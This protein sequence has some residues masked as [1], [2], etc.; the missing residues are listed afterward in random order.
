MLYAQLS[1]EKNVAKLESDIVRSS[2]ARSSNVRG[3]NVGDSNE[4]RL[5]WPLVASTIFAHDVHPVSQDFPYYWMLVDPETLNTLLISYTHDPA[6]QCTLMRMPNRQD[7]F[8]GHEA[9]CVSM[10]NASPF[11]SPEC[12]ALRKYFRQESLSGV[13]ADVVK[14]VHLLTMG[15]HKDTHEA[16][17]QHAQLIFA[18]APLLTLNLPELEAGVW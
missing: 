15:L 6:A 4:S 8:Y 7:W 10:E 11:L 5:I 9:G 14:R 2:K 18:P 1:T 3:S 16:F 12:I 13:D 17:Y